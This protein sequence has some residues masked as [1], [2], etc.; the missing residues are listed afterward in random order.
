MESYDHVLA[1]ILTEKSIHGLSS[2]KSSCVV[3]ALILDS[4]ETVQCC[5]AR[6]CHHALL[7]CY[8]FLLNQKGLSLHLFP[9]SHIQYSG[10]LQK[11]N[12]I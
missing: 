8:Q 12:F 10:T 5:L 11:G 2:L 6:A 1:K 4:E 7:A 9:C 3:W